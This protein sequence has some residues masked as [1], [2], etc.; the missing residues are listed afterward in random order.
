MKLLVVGICSLIACTLRWQ[1]RL[2]V[3]RP[4]TACGQRR[5]RMALSEFYRRYGGRHVSARHAVAAHCGW[6]LP[7]RD[8]THP[9]NDRTAKPD[10]SCVVAETP[11]NT[12][13]HQHC[14]GDEETALL[15]LQLILLDLH[16]YGQDMK[17]NR[18]CR[19]IDWITR[20]AGS[21]F[22]LYA[23][24]Y[25]GYKNPRRMP[26]KKKA[27]GRGRQTILMLVDNAGF[28][29]SASENHNGIVYERLRCR[30]PPG[31]PASQTNSRACG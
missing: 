21:G 3:P 30:V 28:H 18:Y 31:E 12:A 20:L 29:I 10:G 16:R 2:C 8:G 23:Y 19:V 11:A 25:S 14:W 9:L 22:L 6:R 1:C 7:R 26:G 15:G 17:K 13:G 27:P 4:A 5:A 24:R